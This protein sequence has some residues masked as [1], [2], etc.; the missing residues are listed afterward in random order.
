MSITHDAT[1][2]TSIQYAYVRTFIKYGIIELSVIKLLNTRNF[3]CV[4]GQ[5]RDNM[6][7]LR[8]LSLERPACQVGPWLVWKPGFGEWSYHFP[9]WS[10]NHL[11]ET[12][13]AGNSQIHHHTWWNGISVLAS[14]S[15]GDWREQVSQ[16]I[17]VFL[18][19]HPQ[20][21]QR[22]LC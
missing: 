15:G 21:T 13:Q 14:G 16:K 8:L 6:A 19:V 2:M 17:L 7:D 18:Q 3:S 4:Q 5:K 12:P 11:P 10:S 22:S 9:D 20:R 1:G